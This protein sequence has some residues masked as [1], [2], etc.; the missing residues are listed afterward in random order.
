MIAAD[1][2][3]AISRQY[4]SQKQSSLKECLVIVEQDIQVSYVVFFFRTP[5]KKMYFMFFHK[6]KK[7][8]ISFDI[9]L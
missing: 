7:E 3:I 2:E 4:K 5:V 8:I 9:D 6:Y 1:G